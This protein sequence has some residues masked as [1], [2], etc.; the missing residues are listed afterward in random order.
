MTG[1]IERTIGRVPLHK[2]VVLGSRLLIAASGRMARE[3]TDSLA[4]LVPEL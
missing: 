1:I 3:S 2:K 4:S